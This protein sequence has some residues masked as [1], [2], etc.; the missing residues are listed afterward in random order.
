MTVGTASVGGVAEAPLYHAAKFGAV[1]RVATGLSRDVGGLVDQAVAS[2]REAMAAV[3][4]EGEAHGQLVLAAGALE[5]AAVLARQLD[6]M[7]Y[8]VRPVPAAG[9]IGAGSNVA[10]LVVDDDEWVRAVTARALRRAGY[11]V[12][13]APDATAALNLLGDVAGRSVRIVLTDIGMPGMSGH[14]L[15]RT[16]ADRW[17]DV[18]VVLMSGQSLELATPAHGPALPVLH[19]PFSRRDLL[20]AIA[21]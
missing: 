20:A 14:A 15:A 8:T 16:L 9:P 11:G 21:G 2:I 5:R 10:V 12:L 19:K 6:A 17:S 13:E 4:V 7:A 1:V 3:R 18:R